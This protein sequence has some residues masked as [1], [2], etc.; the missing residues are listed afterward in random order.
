MKN[1]K[2]KILVV[3]G[4]IAVLLAGIVALVLIGFGKNK[5][6]QDSKVSADSNPFLEDKGYDKPEVVLDGVLDDEQWKELKTISYNE[7]TKTTVKGFYGKSG[8]YIGAVVEDTD[9]W[10]TSSKV[11][12]NTS[13]ELYLDKTA[14]GGEQPESNCLQFF[15][16]INETSHTTIGNGGYWTET[17][18]IKSYAVKVDGTVDDDVED[19]GYSIEMFVP[20]SQL[21][22]E[23]DVNYGIGFGTVSCKDGSR[24]TWCGIPGV[25]VQKPDT[26]YVFYRD[27]NEIAQP[28]KVNKAKYNVDG[29][30][31][32]SIWAGR[33]TLTFGEGGRGKVSN[34]FAEE[35]LY[36]FYEMQDD[37]LSADGTAV[38][39]N[40]SVEMYLDTLSN[41]GKTPQTDDVQVRI[42]VSGNIE[43]LTGNGTNWSGYRDNVFAGI[44]KT[45][46]GYNMEVFIPWSDLGMEKA[47]QSMNV[48]FGTVDWDGVKKADGSRETIWSGIGSDPQAPDNYTKMTKNSIEV[49]KVLGLVLT[50]PKAPASE[51]T[52]DGVFDEKLWENAE[53]FLYSGMSVKVRYFWTDNGCYMGFDVTDDHVKTESG[54]VWENSSV[55]VYLDYQNNN[56]NPDDKDRTILVDAKGNTELRLG[57]ENSWVTFT[58]S[59]IQS[60][61]KTTD[62]GYKVELYIPWAEFGGAKP[63]KMGVAFGQVMVWES[64]EDGK[65]FE[66]R[67]YSDGLCADPQKPALY[68]DFTATEIVDVAD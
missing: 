57:M 29:K 54:I 48:S 5:I 67:W 23:S 3:S 59:A 51:V 16:D 61:T 36:F 42:D 37:K 68:S 32:D 64:Q 58:G 56:G 8:I 19:K 62:T 45:S 13:F 27:T 49:P 34:Y 11:W 65:E 21:G 30:D 63:S 17:D 14:E 9:L 60:K 46:S 12:E 38:F 39:L 6:P 55:E 26:Y 47:P 28:R 35:G 1:K 31:D 22:G 52:L 2:A 15:V 41:G 20:Y 33:T 66:C 25:D 43:V 18:I 40:D 50:P 44:Q 7:K 4:I 10:A 53:V 24:D